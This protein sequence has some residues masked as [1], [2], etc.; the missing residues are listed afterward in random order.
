MNLKLTID[1][2]AI[3]QIEV[4]GYLEEHWAEWFNGMLIKPEIREEG[5]WVTK[6]TGAVVDQAALYGYLRKLYDLGMP[7]LLVICIKLDG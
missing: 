1:H 4:Q 3:Y 7:L 5:L 2:P 6:L